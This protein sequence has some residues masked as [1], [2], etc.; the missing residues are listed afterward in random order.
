MQ[1][2][3][4]AEAVYARLKVGCGILDGKHIILL[5]VVECGKLSFLK[6]KFPHRLYIRSGTNA[7]PIDIAEIESYFDMEALFK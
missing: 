4:D 5:Q 6:N 3:D 7:I 2:F 1:S